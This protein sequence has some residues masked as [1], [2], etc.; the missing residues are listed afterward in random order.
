MYLSCVA[1]F[2]SVLAFGAGAGA[3][4]EKRGGLDNARVDLRADKTGYQWLSFAAYEDSWWR[5]GTL[6]DYP[7]QIE[8]EIKASFGGNPSCRKTGYA[9]DLWWA[10]YRPGGRVSSTHTVCWDSNVLKDAVKVDPEVAARQFETIVRQAMVYNPRQSWFVVHGD[11]PDIVAVYKAGGVPQTVEVAET[12][13]AHYGLPT[14]DLAKAAADGGPS[15]VADAV[16]SFVADVLNPTNVPAKTVVRKPGAPRAKGLNAQCHIVTYDDGSIRRTGAWR[17]GAKSPRPAYMS[18][19][20]PGAAGDRIEMEFRGTEVGLLDFS[21][22]GGAEY[23]YR[24]DGGEWKAL[25]AGGK[26]LEERHVR[27]ADRLSYS[28]SVSARTDTDRHVVELKVVK[29]GAGCIVGFLLNGSTADE[30]E[31]AGRLPQKLADLDR[32]YARMKPVVYH[33]P[34]GRHALL[35]KTMKRLGEGPSLRIVCLGDSLI[36]D[37]CKSRFELLLER[38]YPNCRV[39]NVCSARSSTGCWWYKDDNRVDGWVFSHDPDLLVIG[40]VSQQDDV[41]SMRSVIRQC[42][43]KRP[44][45]EILVMTPVFGREGSRKEHAWNVGW[46][47][48]PD[49]AEHPF[50]RQVRDMCAEED[51]AFFDINAPLRRYVLDSGMD[52][53]YFH[54]D[55]VHSNVRGQMVL[56]RLIDLW[57]SPEARANPCAEGRQ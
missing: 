13:A 47:E 4:F 27:L 8:R 18:T 32:E 10:Q 24:I 33:P 26:A 52:M 30:D 53:G 2:L 14:L 12:V 44:G 56:G 55:V 20:E 35:P 1:L 6:Y 15:A 28:G 22:A 50:R 43:A 48:D 34:E 36:S 25:P 31:G 41:E 29:P 9:S 16:S 37:T 19:L 7:A 39:T 21:S 23:A 49:K 5:K 45:L 3:Y 46:D 11:D 57:F 40:G 51:V 54:R 42:R 17:M 38:R